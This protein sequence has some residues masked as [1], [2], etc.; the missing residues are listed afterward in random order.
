[1][2]TIAQPGSRPATATPH[3]GGGFRGAVACEWT[4]LWSLRSTWITLAAAVAME[5]CYSFF[6]SLSIQSQHASGRPDAMTSTA[7]AAAVESVFVAQ[8]ALVALATLVI[9]GEYATGSMRSTLQWIPVRS[10]VLLAKSAVVAPVLFVAGVLM[11]AVGTGVAKVLLG[12]YATPATASGVVLRIL[13]IGLVMALTGVLTIGI[14]AALRSLPGT[15]TV[16]FVLLLIV[17]MVLQMSNIPSLESAVN[18]LPSMAGMR[19][20]HGESDQYPP[21]LGLGILAAWTAA[22][23]VAGYWVLRRRD[24]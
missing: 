1:M 9:A 6:M 19:F 15:L 4:K 23:L 24:A 18:Y 7:P 11:G 20:M 5:G 13:S 16:G 14:G 8:L 17:P 3:T 21:L 22:A 2:T 12:Q 10:R